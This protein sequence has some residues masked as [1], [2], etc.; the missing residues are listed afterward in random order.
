MLDVDWVGLPV[1]R[2]FWMECALSQ[3]VHLLSDLDLMDLLLED[4]LG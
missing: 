4:A 1:R 2:C 3:L